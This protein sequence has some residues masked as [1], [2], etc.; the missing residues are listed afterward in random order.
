[1]ADITTTW[2]PYNLRGDWTVSNGSLASG[3]DLETAVIIS[4]FTD[5]RAAPSD[6]IPDG[7]GDP[8]GWWADVDTNGNLDEW[9]SRLWLIDRRTKLSL[10]P[11]FSGGLAIR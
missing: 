11:R 9:G 1:M 4:L 3:N 5:R 10:R 2:S 7:T 6:V 8:R